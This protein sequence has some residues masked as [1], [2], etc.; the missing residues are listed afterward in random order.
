MP[1][2][3]CA[4]FNDLNEQNSQKPKKKRLILPYCTIRPPHFLHFLVKATMNDPP[5]LVP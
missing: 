2:L 3:F 1:L 4:F 5:I